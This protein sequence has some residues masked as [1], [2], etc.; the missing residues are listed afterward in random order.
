MKRFRRISIALA[1]L[2]LTACG[3]DVSETRVFEG[4]NPYGPR[5]GDSDLLAEDIDTEWSRVFTAKSRPP[6]LLVSFTYFPPTTCHKLRVEV[7]KPNAEN[8]IILK[9]YV[10]AA[11]DQDCATVVL[12]DPLLATLN[13]GSFPEGLYT[14][15]LN[16]DQIGEFYS[17]QNGAEQ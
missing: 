3:T 1:I 4:R 12:E 2:F 13:L 10:V 14:V 17:S 16:G 8:Q 11:K 6:Q 15:V 7:S 5:S 9:A